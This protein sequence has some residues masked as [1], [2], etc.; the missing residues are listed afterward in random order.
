MRRRSFLALLGACLVCGC[1]GA[2]HQLP[3]ISQGNLGLAQ[4]EVRGAGGPPPR[5]ALTD[6]EVLETLR[7][8]TRRIRAP[9][10]QV[11]SEMNV[12]MC[13]WQFRASRDGSLNAGAWPNGL[14]VVNRG[15]VE[16]AANEEEV[17][18]VIAHEMGHQAAN[19][20]VTSQRNRAAGAVVGAIL[21][22]AV[23]AAA[24]SGGYGSAGAIR[25]AMETGANIGGAIGGISFSKEQEREAD[26]LAAL[27]LYRAG[28]DLDKARGFL[29][30]MARASGQRETAMLDTHPAGPERLAGWDRAVAEIRASNGRLPRRAS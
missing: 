4:T 9:A 18:L 16:Y 3:E 24:S 17:C 11:C 29:V 20:L 14:I 1:A 22:G 2:V 10:T 12:G 13:E 30:T 19:H 7:S 8:A 26:Y 15:I 5:R 28:V 6:D 25:S 21:L 23:G 27:I